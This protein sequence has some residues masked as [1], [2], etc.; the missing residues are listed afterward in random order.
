MYFELNG[1]VKTNKTL[2]EVKSGIAKI[3]EASN[4]QF[5]KLGE[6]FGKITEWKIEDD[7]IIV[8]ITSGGSPRPHECLIRFKKN[9]AEE[10]GEKHKIGVREIFAGKY[11][12]EFE[13]DKKAV[14]QIKLP[15]VSECKLKDNKCT[16]VFENLDEEMLQKNYIDRLIKLVN[17]KIRYQYYEGKEEYKEYVWNSKEKKMYFDKDP[18]EEMEK[19]GWIRRTSGKGQFVFGREYT[20]LI[21]VF[22]EIIIKH[23]YETLGFYETIFPKFEPWKIP[24]KSGH[25]ATI[26]P[27]AYFVFVPKDSAVEFW[28]DVSDHYKITGEIDKEGILRRVESVGI[29]SYAQCPPFW[30]L[31]EGRTIDE[32]TLPLKIY[33]WSGPTYR[34]ESGGTHGLD[35]IEEFHRIE[36][37]WVGTKKQVTETW[38]QTIDAFK[39]IFDKVLDLELRSA[40]VSPWWMAH[41]GMK[42]EKG[43]EEVGTFD[44]DAY[45]PFKGDRDSEW[46]EIQNTS[47][48]GDKYPKA[49]TVKGT[50]EELWS[51]CAGGSLER[52]AVAFLAQK[53]FDT[54][55]WPEEIR[56]SFEQ[57]IKNIK[58]LKFF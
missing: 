37:L 17:E 54:K 36:T 5:S 49:F 7:K 27:N 42:T 22:K 47:S 29:M 55:N 25:A 19:M 38:K 43:T 20:A 58:P 44:F 35:R 52:W 46:L 8:K 34:N 16:L 14:K 45:L 39:K 50:K 1:Y 32:K 31:L 24:T 3:V 11:V 15:F 2:K 12:V 18:A 21:N 10:L 57:K 41:A 6:N 53:G 30:S 33:D 26:L 13:T 56:K 4:K 23:M 28:E 48:I 51:G 40:K 9:L